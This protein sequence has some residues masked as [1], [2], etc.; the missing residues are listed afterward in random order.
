MA[1]GQQARQDREERLRGEPGQQGADPQPAHEIRTRWASFAAAQL[2]EMEPKAA[3]SGNTPRSSST[4]RPAAKPWLT[5]CW[6]PPAPHLVGDVNI[7]EVCRTRSLAGAGGLPPERAQGGARSTSPSQSSGAIA[8]SS[9]RLCSTWCKTRR[10]P[11]RR[12]AQGDAVIT[13]RAGG[14]AVTLV[15]NAIAWHWNCMSS[16][17]DPGCRC[18]QRADFFTRWC[19]GVT[20]GR[21]LG[22]TLA[23]T[24]V[25]APPR[26]IECDS[27]P[28]RTDFR[29]L[30]PLP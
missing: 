26:L 16:T 30:I 29:I 20:V 18:H 22:L 2:L 28:G 15:A 21:V 25:Q 19:Q 8:R 5:A 6:P 10:R 17:A 24:F 4:G 14:P 23:Q 9:F 3:T 13:L 12:I 11:D 1:A 27:V 7:H